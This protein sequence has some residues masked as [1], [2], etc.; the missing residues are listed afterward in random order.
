[1]DDELEKY[2]EDVIEKDGI[3]KPYCK[4]EKNVKAIVLG[5]DPSVPK[6]NKLPKDEY[7]SVVFAIGKEN[8]DVVKHAYGYRANFW[9]KIK[10]NL[11]ILELSEDCLYIDNLCRIPLKEET[12]RYFNGKYSALVKAPMENEKIN[13]RKKSKEMRYNDLKE[14]NQWVKISMDYINILKKNLDSKFNCK[15][16]VFI[17]SQ[18]LLLPLINEDKL[19]KIMN[20]DKY[21][22]DNGIFINPDENKLERTIIPL[23]RHSKYKLSKFKLYSN[24]IMKYLSDIK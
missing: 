5:C 16:P 22:E 18:Y 19:D 23:F 7:L 12:S 3:T 15:I 9:S 8:D 20:A 14:P 4:N 11:D 17:T 2:K 24:S 21:Y 6:I 10:T 1:M 13:K